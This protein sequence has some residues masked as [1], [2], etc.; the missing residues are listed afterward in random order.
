MGNRCRARFGGRGEMMRR[1]VLAVLAVV[2]LACPA[3]AENTGEVGFQ[4]VTVKWDAP[5]TYPPTIAAEVWVFGRPVAQKQLTPK[6]GA[7]EFAFEDGF[8][9]VKGALSASF[10]PYD[11]TGELRL[12]ALEA[13]CDFSGS[14]PVKPRKLANFAYEA[15]FDY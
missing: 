9:N 2:L 15:K 8:L 13:A 7:M 5:A 4:C 3:M 10:V 6:D 1:L 14:F 11:G 12:D